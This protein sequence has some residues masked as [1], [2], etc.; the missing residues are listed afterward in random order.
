MRQSTSDDHLRVCP[1]LGAGA[2]DHA[3]EHGQVA[4]DNSG[5]ELVGGVATDDGFRHME[6]DVEEL[7][8]VPRQRLQR[9]GDAGGDGSALVRT[10]AADYVERRRGAQVDDDGRTSVAMECGHAVYDAVGAQLSWLVDV[11]IE[12]DVQISRDDHRI[13]TK[14]TAGHLGQPGGHARHDAGDDDAVDLG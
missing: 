5:A 2:L 13:D 3:L 8:G 14:P 1:K 7:R 12:T 9:G 6:L 4:G 10:I 11:E